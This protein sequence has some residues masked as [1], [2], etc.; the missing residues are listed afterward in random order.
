MTMRQLFS[1]FIILLVAISQAQAAINSITFPSPSFRPP[2]TTPTQATQAE[3]SFDFDADA[4]QY[5]VS[6]F[7]ST[8]LQLVQQ[9]F[10]THNGPLGTAV[11]HKMAIGLNE[12]ANQFYLTIRDTTSAAST[13][14]LQSPDTAVINRDTK[15]RVYSVSLDRLSP[16]TRTTSQSTVDLAFTINGTASQY[17]VDVRNLSG[18]V[19]SFTTAAG[20]GSVA[21]VNLTTGDNNLFLRVRA[22]DTFSLPTTVD[23]NIVTIV[24]D[25]IAP[26]V[27]NLQV[28]FPILPTEDAVVSLQG[29]TEP[30][31][32]VRV[33]NGAGEIYQERANDLGFFSILGV[34]LPFLPPGPTSTTFSVTARDYA[35]QL[36][37]T[38]TV[39]ADRNDG[40]PR[41]NYVQMSPRDGFH[42]L[43][44]ETIHV[45]GSVGDLNGPYQVRVYARAGVGFPLLE[46]VISNLSPFTAFEKDISL[47]PDPVSPNTD[48]VYSIEAEVS[49]TNGVSGR[50]FL[51]EIILDV[52]DPPPVNFSDA[53]LDKV[54][55][56]NA[57]AI[58]IEGET[59][60]FSSVWLSNWVGL[61]YRPSS[62]VYSEATNAA[63]GGE[64]RV[65]LDVD[66]LPEER[67][68]LDVTTVATSTRTGPG[69]KREII[70]QKDV[71]SPVVANLTI[72]GEPE[73]TGR[74]HYHTSGDLL[75]LR[76]LMNEEMK[77]EP[78][79][80]VTER[81][82]EALP[83]ALTSVVVPGRQYE[84][85]YVIQNSNDYNGRADVVITGGSD[86]AGN[87]LS[88]EH[89]TESVI[90][91]DTLAPVVATLGT[92]P[93]DGTIISGTP[94]PIRIT[95]TEHPNSIEPSSGVN[96]EACN[97][98]VFG[99]FETD[100]T[101]V[102]TGTLTR[103]S[104]SVLEFNF[105]A[106]QAVA[107][108]T[109][110]IIVTAVDNAGN[111]T[112]EAVVYR[113]DTTPISDLFIEAITP[114]EN[115]NL[116]ENSWPVN[117]L[118]E[119]FVS[120]QFSPGVT[121]E[122]D[123]ARS[124]IRV[125]NL[126]PIPYRV[127][128]TKST[129]GVDTLIFT[130]EN[131]LRTDGQHDGV[132]TIRVAPRD[133]AGNLSPDIAFNV[134]YD[135]TEPFVQDGLR[136]LPDYDI[137]TG[138][139]FFPQNKSTVRGPLR[140]IS[141]LVVDG[142][143]PYPNEFTGSGIN[144]SL[145]TGADIQMVL[146]ENHPTTQ[147]TGASMSTT[148]VVTSTLKFVSV[149]PEVYS[150]CWPGTR[151]ATVM[152][153]LF[154]DNISGEPAGLPTTGGFD[155]EW[156]IRVTPK[157]AAG[158]VGTT[159]IARFTY[160]TIAPGLETYI[161]TNDEHVTGGTLITTGVAWDNDKTNHDAGQGVARVAVRLEAVDEWG[162]TTAPPLINW[163]DVTMPPNR[164]LLP[165]ETRISWRFESPIRA[166]DGR[167]RLLVKA[168]DLAGN[169][170][171]VVRELTI[172][173]GL[174]ERPE[175][176]EPANNS[177]LPGAVVNFSWSRVEGASQ[178]LVVL[179]DP[180]DN[181][182]R[183]L[184]DFPLD[185]VDINL[186]HEREGI[187]TWTVYA[188]DTQQTLGEPAR[189]FRFTLDNTIPSVMRIFPF[190]ATVP[191]AQSGTALNG[192]VRIG[193]TF[194][195]YMDTTTSPVVLFQPADPTIP[196]TEVVQI[197]YV[198]QEWRGVVN[199]PPTPNAP[200]Y[201]GMG[202]VYVR[203]A[204]DL[205][206]NVIEPVSE[207]FEVDLGPWFEV[208]AFANPV[209]KREVFFHVRCHTRYGGPLEQLS[210]LPQLEIQQQNGPKQIVPMQVFQPSVYRGVYLIDQNYPGDAVLL[211][212][213]T[214]LEGNTAK[215]KLSFSVANIIAADRFHDAFGSLTVNL[216]ASSLKE[217]TCVALLPADTKSLTLA[218]EQSE[219][220]ILHHF[221]NV[222]QGPIALS[223]SGMARCSLTQLAATAPQNKVGLF[224]R[225]GNK[226]V[227]QSGVTNGG[228]LVSTISALGDYVLATDEKAPVVTAEGAEEGTL[229]LD[230]SLPTIELEVVD[231]GA[232]VKTESII[233]AIDG[234]P[235][236]VSAE[237]GSSYV[238]LR[239]LELLSPGAHTLELK[240]SDQMGNENSWQ[241]GL[242]APKALD[243]SAFLPAPNPARG[244]VTFRWRL[245]QATARGTLRIYDMAG[246]RVRTITLPGSAIGTGTYLWDGTNRSGRLVANG[247][248]IAKL[249]FVGDGGSTSRA[250]TKVAMLR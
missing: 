159:A 152:R 196:E 209:L 176:R 14:E 85:T 189:S 231:G 74:S 55:Y 162:V 112:T 203:Q 46:E 243:V 107:E 70:I 33:D 215:R 49:S 101:I 173:S 50:H 237:Q 245:T 82:S 64:F 235:V 99:P 94:D 242:T 147:N 102:N 239:P 244:P 110:N 11:R 217:N 63:L 249:T 222:P 73:G 78:E 184:V 114:K 38:S 30:F 62:R 155:G 44:D 175:L 132:Y 232:G 230:R 123:L 48:V 208:Q 172:K 187:W 136:S 111:T 236:E 81:G 161:I 225:K 179:R 75:T 157:D 141:A 195:E 139:S 216:E 69:S 200:D 103:Y 201:N 76:V 218:E 168:W 15:T 97:V 124:E 192:Q 20:S 221:E 72:D 66:S 7:R 113:L 36:S 88:P 248:Y 59:E 109:Y 223:K 125:D 219:L 27:N 186:A 211:I 10:I 129:T 154:T 79:V 8:T 52:A 45:Q 106:G 90:V 233:A 92:T 226:W 29:D 40:D 108:G 119:Q 104:P 128:G 67:F 13:A 156:E 202:T 34:D 91:V 65:T 57:P 160:D 22:N 23:S 26:T 204:K 6:V 68:S 96:I 158:N 84:Y 95:L 191:S 133:I 35:N 166:Y 9:V 47:V 193:V 178:Y 138:D 214:D 207:S 122:L 56:T 142:M 105:D 86:L 167:G 4:G 19:T 170:T 183:R 220:N 171:L 43:P 130:F 135:T 118:G 134:I 126:C 1:L 250:T 2:E 199:I 190:D 212:T 238:T 163:T 98:Q 117:A 25:N 16:F 210:T 149:V 80:F 174:F 28:A 42:M 21:G 188:V 234:N 71:T 37:A 87:V 115:S 31:A 83:A 185:N 41:F 198:N 197:S 131:N 24:Y 61:T 194:S 51:G 77:V 12:G 181:E 151:K 53:R 121:S 150:P 169:E 246:H 127:E 146:I 140:H 32:L 228:E 120:V 93:A 116:N 229:V 205:A 206:G 5:R 240:V 54:L 213:G 17:A 145:T 3:L 227:Y 247:V 143:A 60:R 144:T 18:V 100:P 153:E 177:Y 180:A 39:S 58:S 165:A 224:L 241:V 182:V 89:R 137:T 164:D 148:G